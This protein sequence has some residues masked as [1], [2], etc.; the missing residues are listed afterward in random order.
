[1]RQ[2]GQWQVMELE[3]V[4]QKSL[5]KVLHHPPCRQMNLHPH[6]ATKWSC[7]SPPPPRHST[8]I[9]D[10]CFPSPKDG[11]V[12]PPTLLLNGIVSSCSPL[13]Y[14]YRGFVLP[15]PMTWICIP[16]YPVT[17]WNCGFLLPTTLPLQRICAS[18]PQEMN[19]YP[20]PPCHLMELCSPHCPT[21]RVDLQPPLPHHQ[22]DLHF[23]SHSATSC[24]FGKVDCA[25]E[26]TCSFSQVLIPQSD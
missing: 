16:T 3:L 12:S 26:L 11:F 14:H 10:L 25:F 1:M 24:I 18:F 17:K 5:T 15:F 7:V 23:F 19:L 9:E 21:T 20:H 13:L 22:M 6:P 8:T 2:H 4:I